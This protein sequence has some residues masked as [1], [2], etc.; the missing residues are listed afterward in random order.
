MRKQFVTTTERL[1]DEDERV[2]VLL[3]DIGVFA[4]RN[5]FKKHP[6]RIINIG[7]LEQATVSVAAGLA[8]EGFIPL[9]HS[10]APFVVE[11]AFEQIKVDFGYQS[12]GGNFVSVGGSYDYAALGCSH[13]CP[14]DVSLMQAIPG[15]EIIVPGHP[16][17][18]DALMSKT[19]ASGH[20]TYYRLSERSNRSAQDVTFGSAKVIHTGKGPTVVTVG[21]FLDRVTE[22]LAG[23]DATILYYTTITP[24]DAATLQQHAG[25]GRILCVEPF[26][27]GTLAASVTQALRGKRIALSSMGVPREFLTAYGPAA[28]HDQACGLLPADIRAR[29]DELLHV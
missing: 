8:K 14:G 27:E 5:A 10:I 16:A 20:P 23:T 18:L 13:H 12:L 21:P 2:V 28:Y 25:D 6:Q 22:A 1:L 24:F 15:V 26:Y 17:E 3:G 11:R 4:F 9:F 29:Y 19:Y 7:I